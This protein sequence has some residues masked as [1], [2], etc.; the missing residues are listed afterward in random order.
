MTRSVGKLKLA[1]GALRLFE[2]LLGQGHV[3]LGEKR[4]ADADASRLEEREA[5]RAADQHLVRDLQET[6]ED[7]DLVRH[8]GS[9][10]NHD[11]RPLGVVAERRQLGELALEQEPCVRRQEV[12]HALGRRVGAVR[13]A[14]RVVHVEVCQIGQA[15]GEVGVV[16]RLPLLPAAVLEQE[17]LTR[18]EF[19]GPGDNI[20][21]DHA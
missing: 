21:T 11:Q 17:H 5:H 19:L 18:F 7:T 10:E 12:R 13:G 3:L 6:V 15:S 14:E 8:L 2:E 9:A 20:V 4:V 1:S 16:L